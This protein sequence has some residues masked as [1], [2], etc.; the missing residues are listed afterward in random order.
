MSFWTPLLPVGREAEVFAPDESTRFPLHISRLTVM[1]N[2][3]LCKLLQPPVIMNPVRRQ[4]KR[5]NLLAALPVLSPADT[6]HLTSSSCP[7]RYQLSSHLPGEW[8]VAAGSRFR[9]KSENNPASR[10]ETPVR[11]PEWISFQRY[12]MS[13][14]LEK[15]LTL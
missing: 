15:E 8:V 7:R 10:S 1:V 6:P 14:N 11:M 12:S 2:S 4:V 13:W 5:T 9:R 3:D